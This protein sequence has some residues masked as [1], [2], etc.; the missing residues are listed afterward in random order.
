MTPDATPTVT[1]IFAVV[2]L[3]IWVI[4]KVTWKSTFNWFY[5]YGYIKLKTYFFKE[6]L[7]KCKS[8]I[9]PCRGLYRIDWYANIGVGKL[10]NCSKPSAN[11]ICVLGNILHNIFFPQRALI[12]DC[13]SG[14]WG[15]AVSRKP[16]CPEKTGRTLPFFRYYWSVRSM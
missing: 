4:L 12:C 9:E 10:W 14:G 15:R 5:W 2:P 13:V 11:R 3:R 6:N 1:G 8:R 16:I 7:V